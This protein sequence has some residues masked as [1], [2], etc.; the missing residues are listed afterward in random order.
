MLPLQALQATLSE[1]V[2]T[3]KKVNDWTN[4]VI[5]TCLKGL[6]AFGKPFKYLG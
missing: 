1:N 3:H 4:A 2:Y 6:Q 5:D